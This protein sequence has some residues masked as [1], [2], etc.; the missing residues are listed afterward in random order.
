M[1]NPSAN[2]IVPSTSSLTE[3]S[4]KPVEAADGISKSACNNVLLFT[5]KLLA[6]IVEL[7]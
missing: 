1:V 6:L 2:V 5:E 7:P 4:H 3:R